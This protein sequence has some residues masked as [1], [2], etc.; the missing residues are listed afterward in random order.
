MQCR[1]TAGEKPMF[2]KYS[3]RA[4]AFIIAF[5]GVFALGACAVQGPPEPYEAVQAAYG[6]ASWETETSTAA[7]DTTEQATQ[8]AV[9]KAKKPTKEDMKYM[10]QDKD[11]LPTPEDAAQDPGNQNRP[12]GGAGGDTVT[13]D[14]TPQPTTQPSIQ[15][16]AGKDETTTAATTEPAKP[17]NGWYTSGGKTY[18]Y[19]NGRPVTGWQTLQGWKYYFDGSGVLSSTKGIDVS[20]WQ[21]N[22]NWKQVKAD[23]IDFAMIRVGYRGWGQAGNIR[24]D[25][26]YRNHMRGALDAGLNCGV[27]F[28]TQARNYAEGVEEARFVLEKVADYKLTY[29]IVID[30]EYENGG[31]TADPPRTWGM[32]NQERTDAV[33]GFC[34][35]IKKAGYYPMVYASKSWLMDN[36]QVNRIN[37][38][39]YDIWLAHYNVAQSSYPYKY[40]M[41][42]FSSKG[43]V[44]GFSGPIDVNVST[45]DYPAYL[46]K[47]GWN[48]L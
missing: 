1:N 9:K 31:G 10:D 20:T 6:Y 12:S 27:Y 37:S 11:D 2:K 21:E 24:L 39:G 28:Y 35:T 36:L 30:T 15:P 13:I 38:A 26:E 47:N 42:Q 14:P 45:F 40:T 3:I 23:G 18:L 22:I 7:D 48:K 33:M 43:T 44:S 32:S 46:K 34:D 25:S 19:Q 4:L 16:T 5:Y 8:A 29:P 17:Q 41:W